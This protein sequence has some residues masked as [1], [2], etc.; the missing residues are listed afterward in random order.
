MR[1]VH[2]LEFGATENQFRFIT[3]KTQIILKIFR[4]FQEQTKS[5]LIF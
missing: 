3:E 5:F 2:Q 1:Q 4:V